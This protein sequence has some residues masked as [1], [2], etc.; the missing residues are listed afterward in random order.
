MSWKENIAQPF[1]LI[2]GDGK[3][4][5]PLQM[6]STN[7]FSYDFN[8][9]EFEFPEV[10]GTKVDRRL[11]K[12]RRFPIDVYFQGDDNINQAEAFRLSANDTRP[13]IIFHPVFGRLDGHPISI[14]FD[15]S[16]M[17]TT[18]VTIDFVE[19]ITEDGP[20]ITQDLANTTIASAQKALDE[21]NIVVSENV[22][23]EI[24]DV[25]YMASN[26]NKIYE[27]SSGF[28]SDSSISAEYQNA[29]TK[30]STVINIAIGNASFDITTIQNFITYPF[31]FADSVQN[32]FIVFLKQLDTLTTSINTL[33]TTN[34]KTIFENFKSSVLLAMVKS[35]VAPNGNEYQN[36]PDIFDII[37]QLISS[38]NQFIIELNSLQSINGTFFGAFIPNYTLQNELNFA[39]NFAVSNLYQ[40]ALNAQQA[41]IVTLE[42]DSN[43]IIQTHR[44]YGLDIEDVNLNRF[45][46]TNSVSLNELIQL[47]K[48]REL[49]YYV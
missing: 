17:N 11:P 24:S 6:E 43:V 30:A 41:R 36:A 21:A 25:T 18:Q 8:V 37:T 19:S 28:I 44:F 49:V 38:Y 13:W 3:E 16:G 5:N 27:D 12:G 35:C 31:L 29:F 32:R 20:R 10:S 7:V 33:T 2:T 4:W 45:I 34:K 39:V 40:I 48:G 9:S 23:P 42:K 22:T 47:K 1:R 15:S 46:D 26:T 14:K